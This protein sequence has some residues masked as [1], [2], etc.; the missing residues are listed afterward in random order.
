MKS[1]DN[2][3]NL[4]D[5]TFYTN[6]DN[7][8]LK[9]P[10]ITKENNKIKKYQRHNL[11]IVNHF[12][13]PYVLV[14]NTIDYRTIRKPKIIIPIYGVYNLFLKFQDLIKAHI[15]TQIKNLYYLPSL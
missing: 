13:K 8:I 14:T 4:P 10:I 1:L 11:K 2:L 6:L 5:K 12:I 9:F 7:C 3:F 15:T